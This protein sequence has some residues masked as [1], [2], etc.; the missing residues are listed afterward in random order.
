MIYFRNKLSVY[1]ILLSGILL[2]PIQGYALAMTMYSDNGLVDGSDIFTW[3]GGSGQFDDIILPGVPEGNRCFR[4]ISQNWAGW[5]IFFIL[6]DNPNVPNPIDL[7]AYQ[8]GQL[9]FWVRSTFNLKV[10]MRRDGP[11]GQVLTLDIAQ[12]GWSPGQPD[13]WQ[14]VII[15]ISDF[16][17]DVS[18][19]QNIY[20]PFMISTLPF[21]PAFTYYIDFVRWTTGSGSGLHEIKLYPH[22]SYIGVDAVKELV[23]VGYDENGDQ[24]AITPAWSINPP[25]GIAHIVTE[26]GSRVVIQ[27]DAE[28]TV[29]V[30]ASIDAISGTAELSIAD[31]DRIIDISYLIYTDAGL[32]EGVISIPQMPFEPPDPTCTEIT[33]EQE[34]PELEKYYNTVVGI[35]GTAGWWIELPQSADLLLHES[36]SLK[37]YVKSNNDL[38]VKLKGGE[39]ESGEKEISAYG[40]TP[41]NSWQEITIPLIDF[42]VDNVDFT[43]LQNVFLIATVDVPGQGSVFDIDYVRYETPYALSIPTLVVVSGRQILVEGLPLTIKGVCYSPTPVGEGYQNFNVSLH[44]EIY[45]R[46][47]RLIK[48]MGGNVIRIYKPP[49]QAGFLDEAANQGLFVIMDYPIPHDAQLTNPIVRN[50]IKTGF[51]DMVNTWKNHPAV[52]IWNFGNEMNFHLNGLSPSQWYAFANECAGEAHLAEGDEYHPVVAANAETAEVGESWAGAED[53]VIP[54]LDA[55]AVQIYR[56][57]SFGGM[58]TDL[59][60]KTGKPV[61]LTE[62]GADAY[63]MLTQSE[64]VYTQAKSMG[65]QWLE[66]SQNLSAENPDNV[67]TGGCFFA[68]TDDWSKDQWGWPDSSHDAPGAEP[69]W[70][71]PAYYDYQSNNFNMNEEWWG[72]CGLMPGSNDRIL[73]NIYYQL[74][75]VW[76]TDLLIDAHIN[77]GNRLTWNGEYNA[78]DPGWALADYPITL[79]VDAEFDLFAVQ[80]YTDNTNAQASPQYTGDTAASFNLVGVTDST[81]GLPLCWKIMDEEGNPG[82]AIWEDDRGDG[83]AG[84][85]DYQWH[86]MK[87]AAQTSEFP[88]DPGEDYVRLWDQD[89]IWWADHRDA[90]ADPYT[91]GNQ[92]C[93][94]QVGPPN[95]VYVCVRL[96]DA[97]AQEYSS[98]KLIIEFIFP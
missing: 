12:H 1:I 58:F 23:A 88:F 70:N 93:P 60:D 98:N 8:E 74:S 49:T 76:R 41:N 18:F 59:A 66:I 83:T 84:F 64:D 37:F 27:G 69:D 50:D 78:G 47:F 3:D 11:S 46:D 61:I 56:G 57:N 14:E 45:E 42:A 75:Y 31:P 2:F 7:S 72:I 24:L 81:R 68:W 21:T 13:T 77:G 67:V 5:G 15:P 28:G 39:I 20:S 44:P 94:A 26:N 87:D 4:T 9:S 71:N 89:G 73:R 52:L 91:P 97:F 96:N 85:S 32:P 63:D 25:A 65:F 30:S 55:W 43:A 6:N 95:F 16:T 38:S 34:A 10:E 80:I 54:Y 53:A 92:P 48:A 82:E 33:D 79:N 17:S 22:I 19:L 40:W 62:F 35:S 51:L 36:G 29:T 90:D 86:I